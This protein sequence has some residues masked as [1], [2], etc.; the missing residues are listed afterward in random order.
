MPKNAAPAPARPPTPRSID[1]RGAALTLFAERGYHGTSMKDI[2]AALKLRAPS[3]YNHVSAKQELL[4]DVMVETME[5]LTKTVRSAIATSDDTTEQLRRATEAHVRYHARHRR[6]VRIGNNEIAALEEPTRAKV[7]KLRHDYSRMFVA[8]VQRG[9]EEG[10]FETRSPLLSAY[11]ILQM[12]IGVSMWFNPQGEL[13]EDDVVFQYGDIALGVVRA[14][15][16]RSAPKRGK[17]A[18]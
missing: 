5:T 2:A 10:V 8:L 13:S 11:A 15:K 16:L 1:V 12:G 14:E 7:R 9:V 6:E 17:R 18:P 3:L 4:A